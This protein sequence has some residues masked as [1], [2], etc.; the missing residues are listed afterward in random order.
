[1]GII[2]SIFSNSLVQSLI[3]DGLKELVKRKGT[4]ISDGMVDEIVDICAESTWN[5]LKKSI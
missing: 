4:G 3:T 5:N 2:V 1:M